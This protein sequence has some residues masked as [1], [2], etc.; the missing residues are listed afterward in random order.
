MLDALF[1]PLYYRFLIK[2]APLTRAF[3]ATVFRNIMSGVATPEARARLGIGEVPG[4][5]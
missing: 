1:G 2:H 5:D 3:A 4:N